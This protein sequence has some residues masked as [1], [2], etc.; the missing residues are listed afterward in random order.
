VNPEART[1]TPVLPEPKVRHARLDHERTAVYSL[2]RQGLWWLV[3]S[4][5][6]ARCLVNRATKEA[7]TAVESVTKDPGLVEQARQRAERVLRVAFEVIGWE[8]RLEW[9]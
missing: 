9:E 2:N 7:Q 1:T 5:E 4:D 3:L 8:V 6:P